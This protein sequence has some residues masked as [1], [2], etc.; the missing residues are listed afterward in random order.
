MQNT[1]E[2]AWETS[3]YPWDISVVR[4][5]TQWLCLVISLDRILCD[6][7]TYEFD[8]LEGKIFNSWHFILVAMWVCTHM[9][10]QATACAWRSEDSAFQHVSL[11][12]QTWVI[13]AAGCLYHWAISLAL[14]GILLKYPLQNKDKTHCLPTGMCWVRLLSVTNTRNVHTLVLRVTFKYR[15]LF[16]PQEPVWHCARCSRCS[17]FGFCLVRRKQNLTPEDWRCPHSTPFTDTQ[18]KLTLQFDSQILV[19]PPIVSALYVL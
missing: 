8:N 10:T 11:W 18:T 14:E 5:I 7:K 15:A 6:T 2:A 13:A 9:F 19:I 3:P 12:D 1:T 16:K 17:G 4:E